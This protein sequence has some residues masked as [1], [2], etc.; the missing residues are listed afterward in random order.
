[1]STAEDNVFAY[2]A[3]VWARFSHPQHGGSLD[4]EGGRVAKVRTPAASAELE[5]SFRAG[6]VTQARF[7]AYGCPYTLAVG[8]WLAE[9]LEREGAGALRRIDA[10]AIRAALE[11]P[12]ERAHC[13]FMGE[14]AV[15]SL[16]RQIE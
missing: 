4:G 6:P 16:L 5:I 7:R 9:T 11:I 12:E 14:D 10:A 8:E 15:R 13:A 2:P 1:M 3:P